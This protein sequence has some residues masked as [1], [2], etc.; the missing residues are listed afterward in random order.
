M[1]E[2]G[3]N[4]GMG[5]GRQGWGQADRDAGK[6]EPWRKDKDLPGGESQTATDVEG[7]GDGGGE[8]VR[9]KGKNSWQGSGEQA[10]S[11][12]GADRQGGGRASRAA[13]GPTW[14]GGHAGL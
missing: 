11:G 9:R 7:G 13:P 8:Q 2:K 12:R 4:G 10:G 14:L 1:G 5:R 6:R 3:R